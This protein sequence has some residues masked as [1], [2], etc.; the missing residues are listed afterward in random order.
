MA[1]YEFDTLSRRKRRPAR[2]VVRGLQEGQ[3]LATR[4]GTMASDAAA[5]LLGFGFCT[6]NY[7]IYA[8]LRLQ[9]LQ[10]RRHHRAHSVLKDEEVER[11]KL[12]I[13][14]ENL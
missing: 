2:E 1:D 7:L 8:G 12:P 6:L 13:K 14:H 4:P 5:A 11:K 9:L 10:P 3:Q